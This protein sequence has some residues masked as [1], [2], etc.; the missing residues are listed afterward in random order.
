[1]MSAPDLCDIGTRCQGQ[2]PQ[3]EG[4]PAPSSRG[5]L[6]QSAHLPEVFTS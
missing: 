6:G 3:E 5:L 4:L 1:M 2:L